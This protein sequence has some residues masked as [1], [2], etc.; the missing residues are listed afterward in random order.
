MFREGAAAEVFR[1]H[2]AEA[3]GLQAAP[4]P[5]AAKPCHG[6]REGTV[7][8]SRGHRA[9]GKSQGPR[10]SHPA[11]PRDRVVGACHRL[12]R[13]VPPAANVPPAEGAPRSF[14]QPIVLPSLRAGPKH[15][16]ARLS[17]R[18]KSRR[19]LPQRIALKRVPEAAWL[20]G[21]RKSRR[22]LTLRVRLRWSGRSSLAASRQT[23]RRRS[24]TACRETQ[25]ASQ[26]E[27]RREFSRH[28]GRRSCGW[29]AWQRDC[30][31]P[32]AAS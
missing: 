9:A 6:P 32:L 20:T 26:R 23:R 13:S 17:G 2:R 12:R 4:V 1:V 30:R 19:V 10:N 18:H 7:A 15:V 3:L 25:P 11:A 21:H 31:S 5:P 24:R 14:R 16:P 22:A 8:V 28:R 29:C 27:R